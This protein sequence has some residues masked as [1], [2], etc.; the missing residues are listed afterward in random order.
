MSKPGAGALTRAERLIRL[1]QRSMRATAMH[2][3]P[4]LRNPKPVALPQLLKAEHK[5]AYTLLLTKMLR[6]HRK[7]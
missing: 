2:A 4:S 3:T 1:L 6:V 5:P 7:P